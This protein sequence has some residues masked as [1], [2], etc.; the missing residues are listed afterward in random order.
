[1]NIGLKRETVRLEV[2]DPA[3][4]GLYAKEE[5]LIRNAIGDLIKDIL[6]VGSTAAPDLH[7]KPIIDIV[8]AITDFS[9][10]HDCLASLVSLG[11]QYFGDREKSGDYFFAKGPEENRT[12]Y[13]HMVQS[14]GR[15][16][17]E[18]LF[19]RNVLRQNLEIRREYDALKLRLSKAHADDRK[20]YTESKGKFI[21]RILKSRI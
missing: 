13:I 2:H 4:G 15:K 19:F 8:I 12:H 7:A 16:W 14:D 10:V 1:M 17:K 5:E 3:W 20:S 21:E 18:Y 6:H 9:V 11:Y